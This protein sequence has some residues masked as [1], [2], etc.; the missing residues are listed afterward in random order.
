MTLEEALEALAEAQ[1]ALD[2]ARL[3]ASLTLAGAQ[4]N[5][6]Q[7]EDA[8]SDAREKL[9]ELQAGPDAL[10]LA[11]AD[12]AI[13]QAE[14]QIAKAQ[15][16]LDTML[17][18]ADPK[19]VK[20]A[21]IKYDTAAADLAE[22]QK[23]LEKSVMVAPFSGTI[24]SVKVEVGDEVSASDVILTMANLSELRVM[25][26]IDETEITQV[27][28]GQ[29]V[30]ITFDA[31]PGYVFEGRVL[32]V[33]IQGELSQNVVIYEVPISLEGIDDVNLKPGMT[34]NLSIVTAHRDNALLLPVYAVRWSDEGNVVM[35]QDTPDSGAMLIPVQTG[36]TDGT[37][38]EIVRGLNEGDSVIVQYA[39][40][41]EETVF[42][43]GG[44]MGIGRPPE[45]GLLPTGRGRD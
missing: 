23:A 30:R 11:K 6:T 31:F 36:I 39:Q 22:A 3:N 26:F 35:V 18:E 42:G 1:N 5:V 43:L 24:V 15:D 38:V 28:V 19:V 10:A 29:D 27:E 2:L 33:P 4:D 7:V 17:A 44:G 9:A 14:Y 37:Y 25:A 40:Q 32:E 41:E 20:L 8:L 45:G 34:A 21:Q 12:N 13:T 16:D